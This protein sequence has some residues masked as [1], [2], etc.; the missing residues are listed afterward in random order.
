MLRAIKAFVLPALLG[1]AI[2]YFCYHALAGKQGL[3]SWTK[4][5]AE[6]VELKAEL[7]RLQHERAE[8]EASLDRLRDRT[9]DLDYLEEIAR[10]KLSYA[11]PDE[12]LL[13]IR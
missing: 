9:L 2:L 6:E 12:V 10:T 3:A 13:A 8:L 1:A 4:L 5:Q 7:V 11:R